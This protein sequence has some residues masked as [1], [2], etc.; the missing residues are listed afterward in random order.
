MAGVRLDALD[1]GTIERQ[2]VAGDEVAR[3][4]DTIKSEMCGDARGMTGKATGDEIDLLAPRPR[5]Q[6][7]VQH[8]GIIG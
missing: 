1:R 8:V 7:P 3:R 5:R 6:R 4:N 2:V